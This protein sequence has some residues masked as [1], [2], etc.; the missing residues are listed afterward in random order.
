MDTFATYRTMSCRK[1]YKMRTLIVL[2][3]IALLIGF[4]VPGD[5][6]AR[7]LDGKWAQSPPAVRKWL[8]E[9]KQ[10]GSGYLCCS[11]A[12][13]EQVDEEIRNGRY[14]INSKH[15]RGK[16]LL[17]PEDMVINSPN[18]HGRAIAWFRWVGDDGS[19]STVPRDDLRPEVFC[20]APGALF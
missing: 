10:P 18:P 17:V 8:R 20:Y 6:W 19:T 7:D 9:Q 16:W 1:D 14:W 2:V 12:D 3:I 13:G 5:I 15:T 4:L 11:E